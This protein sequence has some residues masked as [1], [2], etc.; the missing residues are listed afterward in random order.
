MFEA[1][2]R[3]AHAHLHDNWDVF[4][5]GLCS[6][7][8]N[9][10]KSRAYIVTRD[11]SAFLMR[12]GRCA[13]SLISSLFTSGFRSGVANDQGAEFEVQAVD[14]VEGDF[15]PEAKSGNWHARFCVSKYWV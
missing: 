2:V 15:A 12:G 6:F 7:S 3:D 10:E 13:G 14:F 8:T 4:E 5:G 9:Y 1:Q 11:T